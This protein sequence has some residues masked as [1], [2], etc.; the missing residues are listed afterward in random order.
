M[1]GGGRLAVRGVLL[2]R[3]PRRSLAVSSWFRFW[4]CIGDCC[5]LG[6]PRLQSVAGTVRPRGAGSTKSPP[7]LEK[8]SISVLS[9]GVIGEILSWMQWTFEFNTDDYFFERSIGLQIILLFPMIESCRAGQI[10]ICLILACLIL[11]WPLVFLTFACRHFMDTVYMLLYFTLSVCVCLAC[12]CCLVQTKITLRMMSA[13]LYACC[14]FWST[15]NWIVLGFGN[16]LICMR[17]PRNIEAFVQLFRCGIS[18]LIAVC[19]G[20]FADIHHP[21]TIQWHFTYWN[22]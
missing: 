5:W 16:G 18:L 17:A 8:S 2:V 4:V 7:W 9:S 19:I 14:L 12:N 11:H 21:S 3:L 20:D 10:G 6:G 15:W 1:V 22:Y 13:S